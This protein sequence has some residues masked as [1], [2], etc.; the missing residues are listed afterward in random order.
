[1]LAGGEGRL[2]MLRPTARWFVW[3]AM[4]ALLAGCGRAVLTARPAPPTP[5][6]SALAPTDTRVARTEPPSPPTAEPSPTATPQLVPDVVAGLVTLVEELAA[7]DQFSGALLIAQEGEPT[8]EGAYGLADRSLEVSNRVDTPFNLGSMNKMFTAT[9]ILQLVE[10][11]KL[12]LDDRIVDHLPDYAN[13]EAATTITIHQLLTHTSGLGDVFSDAYDGMPKDRLQ[14]PEDWLPLF[15]DAPLQ[16][17]PGAQFQYSNAGYVVLGLLLER[18]TGQSYY[19]YVAENVYEPSGM[20]HT[21]SYARDADV[22]HVAIGYTRQGDDGTELPEPVP[23]T[24]RL[25]G[26]GFPAGGGYS[27]VEDLLKFRNALLGHQLL[28][29]ESTEL[30]ITGKIELREGLKYAYGFFDRLV[31]GQRVV[32]HSGGFP[33]ICDFMDIYLDLGAT[34]I[35]LSNTDA[36]CMAVL[37]YLQEHPL[38]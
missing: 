27:T 4:V 33:G 7:E 30:L 11:G 28:G 23:N 16:F 10:Q 12:A 31:G 3:L 18:I 36:G 29:P 26:R 2:T 32:G 37:D 35:V 13:E 9:A 34:V 6:L 15:V 19:D 5:T 14:T 20:R 8:F 38:E 1:V 25:P 24:D 22:P 17:E 21:A